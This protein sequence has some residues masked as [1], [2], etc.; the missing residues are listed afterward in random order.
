[1]YKEIKP[2]MPRRWTKNKSRMERK[3]MGG[4]VVQYLSW[5][6]PSSLPNLGLDDLIVD[7]DAPGSLFG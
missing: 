5:L 6:L 7:P 3:I 4:S 2:Q 1:M